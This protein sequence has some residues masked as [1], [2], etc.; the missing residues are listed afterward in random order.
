MMSVMMVTP[1]SLILQPVH[2]LRNLAPWLRFVSG[3]EY[4]IATDCTARVKGVDLRAHDRRQ[5]VQLIRT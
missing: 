1:P 2:D 5:R 3:A 4:L